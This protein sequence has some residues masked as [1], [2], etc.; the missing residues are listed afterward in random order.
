[1]VR[2]DFRENLQLAL[3]TVRANKLRSFLAILGVIAGSP[4]ATIP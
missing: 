3:D 1:M 2:Q 4:A